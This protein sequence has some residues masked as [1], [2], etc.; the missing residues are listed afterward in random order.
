MPQ[1]RLELHLD[2]AYEKRFVG[3]LCFKRFDDAENTLRRLEQLRQEFLAASDS[4]GVECCRRVALVGRKRA[5]S[6]SRNHR[7]SPAK[8]QQKRE[9]THWFALWLESPE[10]FEPWLALRKGSAEYKAMLISQEPD[11]DIQN[12]RQNGIQG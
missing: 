7:V 2:P 3:I 11:A 6:L 1:S 9:I 12:C 10:I 4:V 5:Q 8:R